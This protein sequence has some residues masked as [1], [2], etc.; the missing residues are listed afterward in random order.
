LVRVIGR[1]EKLRVREIWILLY[2]D[3]CSRFVV[4][5]TDFEPIHGHEYLF[6]DSPAFLRH[7]DNKGQVLC[8]FISVGL[9]QLLVANL[10]T[11][12]YLGHKNVFFFCR[13]VLSGRC[14]E[15]ADH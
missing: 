4:S 6:H 10:N 15:V 9:H 3:P 2:F 11:A 14:L 1:L 12:N 5:R 7:G 13:S 8:L